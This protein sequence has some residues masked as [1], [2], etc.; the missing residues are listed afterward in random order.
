MPTGPPR[1]RSVWRRVGD[2]SLRV[3]FTAT[4]FVATLVI[5]GV[6]LLVAARILIA[7]NLDDEGHDLQLHAR[8]A[9]LALGELLNAQLDELQ[10]FTL[11][12]PLQDRVAAANA[13]SPPGETAA[14]RAARL[15]RLAEHWRAAP[16]DDPLIVDRLINPIAEDFKEFSTRFVTPLELTLTDRYGVLVATTRRLPDVLL[17]DTAWWQQAWRNGAGGV[18]ISQPYFDAQYHTTAIQLAVPVRAHQ[19]AE[20]VGIL[21]ATYALTPYTDLISRTRFSATG[22][23]YLLLSNGWIMDAYGVLTALPDATWNAIEQLSRD[24]AVEFGRLPFLDVDSLVSAA[25]VSGMEH[26]AP[27]IDQLGWHIVMVRDFAEADADS[28]HA[29][30]VL[31]PVVLLAALAA[32]MVAFGVAV[33]VTRPIR[34]LTRVTQAV[35][36]GDLNQRAWHPGRDEL[37]RLAEDFNRMA[38]AVQGRE[39]EL[40]DERA[41][42][43]R[44][45]A[46][47]TAE[48]RSANEQLAGAARLKDEFLANMSHELRT[49]L[50]AILGLTEV[51]LEGEQGALTGDQRSSLHI[52]DDSS[53]HLLALINDILDLSKIEAG[54]LQLQADLVALDPI[55]ASSVQVIRAAADHRR[56]A[57][58]YQNH[59]AGATLLADPRRL[60]QILVNLLSNAVKFT[61]DGGR[62]GLHVAAAPEAAQLRLTVW[63]TGIGI[64]PEQL[65]Y[66][67]KPFVQ[68]DS[69]LTRQYEGSGL[70]LALVARLTEL[71]G[72][73]VTVHSEPGRGSQF[74]VGLPWAGTFEIAHDVSDTPAETVV[75]PD[76]ASTPIG[77]LAPLIL[78]AEDSAESASMFELF[79]KRQGY[80]VA[81]AANGEEALRAAQA[82]R[83][84]LIVTDLQMPEVDGLEVI[85][86]LR[87]TPDLAHV[88]ILAV[89]AHAMTGMRERCLAAGASGYLSKPLNL[90]DLGRAVAEQLSRP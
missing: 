29:A 67:F 14:D 26:T 31:Q 75:R 55:C 88:P 71:H 48:L 22:R 17:A 85:R 84:A 12:Q 10:A 50:N 54:R 37:G 89:T 43:A 60:K 23:G 11:S 36:A 3:K 69:S 40:A 72:G 73:T 58:D 80:R 25:A 15:N 82:D 7:Q 19:S 34:H 76:S 33:V 81:V 44:R 47:Q 70:G 42:L 65:P 57:V 35:A 2:L 32:A 49:P 6:L 86:R 66:L 64:T 68:I 30:Q 39:R 61:P 27:V 38:E 5:V 74:T 59:A 56:L 16:D 41:A 52:I 51:L 9:A 78:V 62:V 13:E 28:Q 8:G 21:G 53:R 4:F 18:G 90:R 79:L 1:P 46:E 83:P 63:D 20:V 45:V 87:A 77:Q 24:T